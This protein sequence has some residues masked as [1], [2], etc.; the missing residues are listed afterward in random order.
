VTVWV[1]EPKAPREATQQWLRE[2]LMR[3]SN[4]AFL[5][6]AA[7]RKNEA[8]SWAILANAMRLADVVWHTREEGVWVVDSEDRGLVETVQAYAKWRSSAKVR[9]RIGNEPGGAGKLVAVGTGAAL[10]KARGQGDWGGR[11]ISRVVWVRSDLEAEAGI[12]LGVPIYSAWVTAKE[13]AWVASCVPNP[14]MAEGHEDEQA[15]QREGSFGRLLPGWACRN[16]EQGVIVSGWHPGALG[17]IPL[18][19]LLLDDDG[20]LMPLSGGKNPLPLS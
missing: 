6:R 10:A 1:G 5:A 11:E 4:D 15:G 13:G 19:G 14:K 2:E 7:F 17:E 12:D 20:F 16:T 8:G 9:I 18:Q 3:L